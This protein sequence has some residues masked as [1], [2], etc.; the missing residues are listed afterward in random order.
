MKLRYILPLLCCILPMAAGAVQT[1]VLYLSGKGSDDMVQWEFRCSAGADSGH[2]RKIG[3]PSQ[4]ELQGFGEY[5]YGRYYFNDKNAQPSEETGEYRYRF[6]VPASWKGKAVDI[7]FDGVMTDAL[8]RINGTVAGEVHQGAFYRFSYRISEL[9]K[10]GSSNLL[11]VKV[12]KQSD[13]SSVNAAERRADWW[14][15]GGI[16]RPVW[17][18]AM[19]AA[20]IEHIALNP[21]ADGT[22]SAIIE[23]QQAPQGAQI[24]YRLSDAGGRV[25][26]TRTIALSDSQTMKWDGI[27]PWECEHPTLYDISVT[28]ADKDGRELHSIQKRIGFRTVELREMDGLYVNGTK[29]VLKGVNRHCF[30]PESG[31]TTS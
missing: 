14:L 31:R 2:W 1:D 20:H 24:R 9:L 11:E 16:F 10:Y 4:W 26:G 22:L 8:V 19:P 23:T 15:F 7:V 12:K 13:N 27:I 21:A 3:V 29:V 25:L 28:L 17:L 30:H 6:K 18:R 5:T